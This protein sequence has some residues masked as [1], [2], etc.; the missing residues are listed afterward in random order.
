MKCVNNGA[1]VIKL[2]LPE[3]EI[4]LRRGEEIDIPAWLFNTLTLTFPGLK[5]VEEKPVS[6]K[7]IEEPKEESHGTVKVNKNKKS[8]K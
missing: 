2:A 1:Q 3:G 7:P 5:K 6:V 4:S 8:G